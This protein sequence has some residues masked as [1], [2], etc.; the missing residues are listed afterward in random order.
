VLT[1]GLDGIVQAGSGRAG[2]LEFTGIACLRHWKRPAVCAMGSPGTSKC[3]LVARDIGDARWLA[4]L[5]TARLV[6]AT[7]TKL[8]NASGYMAIAET[9]LAVIDREESAAQTIDRKRYSPRARIAAMCGSWF[10]QPF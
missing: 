9:C 8:R 3:N 7:L 2:K 5:P 10:Y 6:R 4:R 1:C